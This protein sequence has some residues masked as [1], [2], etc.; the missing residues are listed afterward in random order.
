MLKVDFTI[1]IQV[2]NFLACVAILNYLLFRPVMRIIEERKKRIEGLGKEAGA[3][4]EKMEERKREYERRLEEI[5]LQALESR[6]ML[7]RDGMERAR[8]ILAQARQDASE[9]LNSAKE[10]IEQDIK[11]ASEQL[12]HRAKDISVEIAEKLLGRKVA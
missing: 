3:L 4:R 7:R 6:E 10:R 1:L 2:V 11:I 8:E 12:E 5:K 9:I